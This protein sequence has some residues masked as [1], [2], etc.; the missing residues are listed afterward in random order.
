M[1]RVRRNVETWRVAARDAMW[2]GFI[3]Q[4]TMQFKAADLAPHYTLCNWIVT[5]PAATAMMMVVSLF[6]SGTA[7][8]GTERVAPGLRHS[9]TAHMLLADAAQCK[10]KHALRCHQGGL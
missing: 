10:A 4:L 9:A 1:E 3:A 8:P 5:V 2:A 7:E 6:A